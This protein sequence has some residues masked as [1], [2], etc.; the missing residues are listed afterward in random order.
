MKN[1][2]QKEFCHHHDSSTAK[3]RYI[4]STLHI[5]ANNKNKPP[6]KSKKDKFF[7]SV[8]KQRKITAS[9]INPRGH[10]C[11]GNLPPLSKN[12]GHG[13]I[14]NHDEMLRPSSCKCLHGHFYD[15]EIRPSSCPHGHKHERKQPRVSH[16]CSYG[17]SHGPTIN[18][19]PRQLPNSRSKPTTDHKYGHKR[20]FY[21][22]NVPQEPL[23]QMPTTIYSQNYKEN[24]QEMQPRAW[25]IPNSQRKR[26]VPFCKSYKNGKVFIY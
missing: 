8:E 3:E 4:K 21:G 22:I 2:Q 11:D 19:Y 5:D 16:T 13:H 17:H 24:G 15:E 14:Q 9:F 1:Y 12:P 18:P 25:A 7:N 20:K 10:A 26:I 23:I 6:N